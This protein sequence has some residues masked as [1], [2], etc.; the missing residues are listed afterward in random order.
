[1]YT[2]LACG[3]RRDERTAKQ[4]LLLAHLYARTD[5]ESLA[6]LRG[7]LSVSRMSWVQ[8]A[9]AVGSVAAGAAGEWWAQPVHSQF[10]G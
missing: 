1:M 6:R 5:A 8:A 2:H 3:R 4:L 9:G 7:A 10:I